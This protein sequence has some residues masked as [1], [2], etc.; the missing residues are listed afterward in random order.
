[1]LWYIILGE[2]ES[3]HCASIANACQAS[4][5]FINTIHK[6][7]R[8]KTPEISWLCWIQWLIGKATHYKVPGLIPS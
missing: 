4:K 5:L 3:V 7:E 6:H 8:K 1:M 2:S